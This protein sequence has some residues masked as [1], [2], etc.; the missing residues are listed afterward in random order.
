M[1]NLM[2]E[3]EDFWYREMTSVVSDPNNI[4]YE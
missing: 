1:L 2:K 4:F 3:K